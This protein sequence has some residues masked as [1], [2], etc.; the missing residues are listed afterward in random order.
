MY[1][2]KNFSIINV[3]SN[4]KK[5]D[6]NMDKEQPHPAFDTVS[7]PIIFETENNE[8]EFEYDGYICEIINDIN[9]I[10]EEDS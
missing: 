1:V 6:W 3:S 5:I 2:N 8:I 9:Q 10:D 4:G 7:R